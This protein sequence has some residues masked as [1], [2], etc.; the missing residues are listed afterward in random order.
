MKILMY[1]PKEKLANYYV[2]RGLYPEN[3]EAIKQYV[4]RQIDNDDDVIVIPECCEII[5]VE[6]E[7]E[8]KI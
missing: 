8:D 5:S 2:N 7:E 6:Q 3:R 1:I 4:Q